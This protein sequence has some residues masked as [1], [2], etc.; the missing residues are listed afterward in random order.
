[1]GLSHRSGHR[2]TTAPRPFLT[3][4]PQ[5]L[6]F[7]QEGSGTFLCLS[8]PI[9]SLISATPTGTQKSPSCAIPSEGPLGIF[10][11][12]WPV[13]APKVTGPFLG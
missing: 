5:H 7:L 1:M 6:I 8:M 12:L 9:N 4:P 3:A 2:P 11:A 13:R 10:E